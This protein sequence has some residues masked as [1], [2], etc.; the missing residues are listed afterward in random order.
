MRPGIFTPENSNTLHC[1]AAGQSCFNEAGDF[2]PRK[3]ELNTEY[4]F[5][6][7]DASMRP[8]IFTP[9]NDCPRLFDLARVSGFNEAGDFHP[10]KLS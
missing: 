8:G 9:E 3:P 10:R 4:E 1:R 6:D 5:E 2:H 7:I